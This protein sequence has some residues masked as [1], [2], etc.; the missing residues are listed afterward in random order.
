MNL[1]TVFVALTLSASVAQAE[2]LTVGEQCG[3]M[4][5][6]AESAM[7]ARQRGA[8]MSET[9]K[10]AETIDLNDAWKKLYLLQI[11]EAYEI[12]LKHSEALKEAA[13]RGFADG[14]F[15]ACLDNIEE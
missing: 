6:M 11:K 1:K 5:T 4:S 7:K 15:S 3:M 8:P 12:D 13:V 2:E 9:Y 14:W 10:I